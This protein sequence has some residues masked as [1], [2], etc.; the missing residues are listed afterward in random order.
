MLIK[1]EGSD[2]N[3]GNVRIKSIVAQD[4]VVDGNLQAKG[5]TRIDGVV[6]G[7]VKIDEMLVLGAASKVIG[8]IYA[9]SIMVGGEVEGD[10]AAKEKVTISGTGKVTGNLHT[11]KLIVDENAVFRGQC[12]M[13]DEIPQPDPEMFQ[14]AQPVS[15]KDKE[16]SEQKK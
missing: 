3:V 13:G 8:N 16:T 10:L 6:R 2:G 1:K 12:F 15:G 7:N 5:A 4:A 9:A 14:P 11:K